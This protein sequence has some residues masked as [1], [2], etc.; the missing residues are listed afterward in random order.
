[1]ALGGNLVAIGIV[2][3]KAVFGEFVGWG[4]SL[5]AFLTFAVIGFALLY[6]VRL[7]VDFTLLPGTRIAKELSED[8]NVA[9]AFIESGVL[10]SVALILYFAI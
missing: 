2:A 10:V 4:E 5:A 1:V 7:I 3:F 9:V 6:I 8:R